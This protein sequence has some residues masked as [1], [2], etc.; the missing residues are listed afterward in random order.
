MKTN[1]CTNFFFIG[2]LL[3]FAGCTSNPLAGNV[4]CTESENGTLFFKFYDNGKLMYGS[5]NP[6]YKPS[7]VWE[8]NDLDTASYYIKEGQIYLTQS[9][10]HIARAPLDGQQ[11]NFRFFANDTFSDVT[12]RKDNC[13]DQLQKTNRYVGTAYSCSSMSEGEV[14]LLFVSDDMMVYR[15]KKKYNDKV[16]QYQASDDGYVSIKNE[17]EL[18]PDKNHLKADITGSTY[19]FRKTDYK[20]TEFDLVEATMI[21]N[22]REYREHRRTMELLEEYYGYE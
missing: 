5:Y 14:E 18:I 10:K 17:F 16:L 21:T 8:C 7:Y 13:F 4:F 12:Y 6:K 3:L 1:F 20:P 15:E 2:I 22:E 19:L 9:G 11:L